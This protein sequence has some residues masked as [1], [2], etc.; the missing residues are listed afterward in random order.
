MARI[1]A[2]KWNKTFMS[3]YMKHLLQRK[4]GEMAGMATIATRMALNSMGPT[5][6]SFEF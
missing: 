5:S 2:A 4:L 3:T 1:M 6:P